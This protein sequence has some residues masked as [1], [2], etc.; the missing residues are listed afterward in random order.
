MKSRYKKLAVIV[1]YVFLYVISLTG[2][3]VGL[4]SVAEDRDYIILNELS[5][6]NSDTSNKKVLFS[7]PD[8]SFEN[9]LEWNNYSYTFDS[10]F[11]SNSYSNIFRLINDSRLIIGDDCLNL[12][13]SDIT[14]YSDKYY[15]FGNVQLLESDGQDF[16]KM[17]ED[18]SVYIDTFYA[19][20]IKDYMGLSEDGYKCLLN[21]QIDIQ[22]NNESMPFFI[23]GVYDEHLSVRNRC[24]NSL[25]NECFGHTFFISREHMNELSG[26]T[27]YFFTGFELKKNM[28]IFDFIKSRFSK[29]ILPPDNV[30]NNSILIRGVPLPEFRISSKIKSLLPIPFWLFIVFPLCALLGV[31]ALSCSVSKI[32]LSLFKK[33]Q[34]KYALN[35]IVFV[36]T[37]FILSL[38]LY[39]IFANIQ[40]EIFGILL[41]KNAI[42]NWIY[43]LVCALTILVFSLATNKLYFLE[44]ISRFFDTN[45]IFINGESVYDTKDLYYDDNS[46]KKT[47]TAV[48]FSR[49]ID[50]NSA[51][52]QRTI[53]D[54]LLLLSNG[55]KVYLFGFESSNFSSESLNNDNLIVK[56]WPLYKGKNIIKKYMSYMSKRHI[57][58]SFEHVEDNIDVVLIYSVMSISQIN[59]IK[60]YSKKHQI[61]LVFDS[62]EFQNLLEQ[63]ASSFFTYYLPNIYINKFAIKNDSCVL[64]ISKYLELYYR[65][66][67]LLTFRLPFI[68]RFANTCCVS[69][70]HLLNKKR[71]FA[72]TG[73]PGKK[74][75]LYGII[76]AFSNLTEQELKESI[77]VIAGPKPNDLYKLGV[78]I[79]LLNKIKNSILFVGRQPYSSMKDIYSICDFTVLLKKSNMRHAKADFPSKVSQSLSFGVPVIANSSSDLS[80]FLIDGYNGLVFDGFDY[81]KL[82][83]SFK[84]ALKLSN[85]DVSKMKKN[86]LLTCNEKLSF[87]V[88]V[89]VFKEL[90]YKYKNNERK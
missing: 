19:N 31:I 38:L 15:N 62:V 66:K 72:Y 23:K 79:N 34:N 88:G 80:D 14:H 68:N 7:F 20:T 65:K 89:S 90:L 25:Y 60:Q 86:S 24:F 49:G 54:C 46:Q 76:K 67:N 6:S 70:R 29:N 11:A 27:G 28:A 77:L 50:P 47:K 75:D 35:I 43:F 22:I 83:E 32:M 41:L 26:G 53:M 58:S 36:V 21:K 16:S 44:N 52:G 73:I 69:N 63:N 87:N 42:S 61:N 40:G 57:I 59:A 55:Y 9:V 18:G 37:V 74:D 4:S 78:P 71:V 33:H 8:Y 64:V 51:G 1:A 82:T 85:E 12:N 45:P 84:K 13:I 48:V 30:V 81:T 39:W 56:K 17:D 3:T 10:R 2:V 5:S